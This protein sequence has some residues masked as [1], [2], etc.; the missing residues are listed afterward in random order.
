MAE[1]SNLSENLCLS[2][3]SG[4][5]IKFQ[6]KIK[7]LCQGQYFP[8]Y[9]SMGKC[10]ITPGGVTLKR[11]IRPG[12]NSNLSEISCLSW[13]PASL[14]KLWSKLKALC[15]GQCQICFFITQGQVTLRRV[16][17]YG[18]NSNLSE[19]LCLSLLSGSLIKFQW[20]IKLL[21]LGQYFP[22][23]K[24]MGKFF[25][26]QGQVTLK[27]MNWPGPNSNLT[28]ILCLSRIPANLEELRLKLKALPPGQHFPI[29]SLWDL[30]VAMVTTVLNKPVPK[31]YAVKSP[32]QTILHMKF[33]QEWPA[34]SGDIHVWKCEHTDG[35]RNRAILKAH[36]LS[37]QLRWA[38]NSLIS[39]QK[40]I[41]WVLNTSNE[42]SQC[43][44]LCSNK[45]NIRAQ[46]FKTNSLW[47]IS[48]TVLADSIH[49]ILIFF[50][51]KIWVAFALQKLL[52]FFQ[53]KIS[54]YLRITRCKF[55]RILN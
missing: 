47:V 54:A 51:D 4:S 27:R 35:R 48:L 19:I 25:I 42:Y 28:E 29:I 33:D 18:W 31:V 41:L 40:H 6:W 49:N 50:A 37:P 32:T 45:Q 16:V 13:I 30:F 34:S 10:F 12:P 15:P 17:Q 53:Q 20:K 46:L 43:M 11:M 5:L 23:F 3:L 8:H 1:I 39:P 7:L 26:A 24:S 14:K 44:F 22:H 21:S 52:T 36:L 38:N 55:I 9:K 2:L